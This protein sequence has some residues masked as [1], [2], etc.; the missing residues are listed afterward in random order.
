M[1][2]CLDRADHHTDFSCESST[3]ERLAPPAN[4]ARRYAG[5]S[6]ARFSPRSRS[7]VELGKVRE[8]AL[9]FEAKVERLSDGSLLVLDL[10]L[11]ET[12]AL[13]ERFGHALAIDA[14]IAGHGHHA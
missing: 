3:P 6:W 11:N 4:L 14:H 10:S 9:Y 12:L 1:F 13:S 7:S 5:R 2:D 8:V